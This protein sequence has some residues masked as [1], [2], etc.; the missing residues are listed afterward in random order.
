MENIMKSKENFTIK[1]LFDSAEQKEIGLT[2]SSWAYIFVSSEE[3]TTQVVYFNPSADP[4]E[5]ES[6]SDFVEANLDDFYCKGMSTSEAEVNKY[7]K[8]DIPLITASFAEEDE[9][10][11]EDSGR[12]W[13]ITNGYASLMKFFDGG[14]DAKDLP[15]IVSE[16]EKENN[17]LISDACDSFNDNQSYQKDPYAYYGVSRRDFC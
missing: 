16:L 5:F 7:L 10:F 8:A 3:K 14:L 9:D 13:K 1:P 15:K 17:D 12:T 6:F 11:D 2:N 4:N